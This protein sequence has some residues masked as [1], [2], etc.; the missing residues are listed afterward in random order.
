MV[1]AVGGTDEAVAKSA[2]QE[3]CQTYWYPLYA[4][5]RHQGYQSQNAADLTQA[6]FASLLSR[7]DLEKVDPAH[8]KFRSFLIASM[9]HFLINEW[10]KRQAQKRGGGKKILSIDFATADSRYRSEP[11]DDLTSENVFEKNWAMTLLDRTTQSLRKEFEN[12]GKSHQFDALQIFLAGK[13]PETTMGIVA[14]QLG[15]TEVAAKVAVHR[16]RQRFGELLRSEIE[17]TVD[18]PD[19]IDAEIQ[20][21][22]QVLSK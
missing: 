13:S 9:K 1:R 14:G 22:F 4:Y 8:G 20:H 19:E 16:M 5:V 18:H 3:L 15:M 7:K 6:F 12:R 2:L 11:A 21:L 17:K 10:D